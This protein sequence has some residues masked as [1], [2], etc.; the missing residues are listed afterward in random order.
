MR[1]LV[2]GGYGLIGA[3]VLARLAA[4]GHALAA[5]GRDVRQARRRFPAV[6]WFRIDLA[7]AGPEDWTPALAGV[8]AVVNCAGALQEGPGDRLAKVH[9]EGLKTLAAACRAAGVRRLVHISAAGVAASPGPFGATKREGEA[10]L[11]AT[12]LDWIVLRPGLV[13][14]PQAF[15]GSALLR[16]LA[17]F[18]FAIPVL[19]A[20]AVVQVVAGRDVAAAVAAAIGPEAPSRLAIDLV[21][22]EPTTLAE[23]LKALRGWLGLAPAPLLRVPA[24]LARAAA[25]V[26]DALA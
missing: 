11:A 14:A 2:V 24:A 4:D 26:A 6:D 19:H 7:S 16:A 1:V 21:A 18:P 22:A 17:A 12:D 9:A 5:A 3:G 25:L 8:D 23:I 20:D 15:G 13:L 10:A